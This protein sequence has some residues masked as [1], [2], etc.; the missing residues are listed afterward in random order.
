MS[1][2][3]LDNDVYELLEDLG[4]SKSPDTNIKIAI[5]TALFTSKSV[6]LGRAASIAG[7]AE[8]D[9]ME[10]L[11]NNHIPWGE[12]DEIAMQLDNSFLKDMR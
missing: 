3:N 10:L 6:S 4:Q 11:K 8:G 1:I 12:Y 9:F 5:A 2:L 7:M